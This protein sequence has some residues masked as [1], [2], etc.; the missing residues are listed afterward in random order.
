MLKVD[1]KAGFCNH[2][3]VVLSDHSVAGHDYEYRQICR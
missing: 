3:T 1:I 2:V